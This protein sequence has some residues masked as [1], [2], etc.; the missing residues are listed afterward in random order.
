MGKIQKIKKL[1]KIIVSEWR[2]RYR[3]VFSNEQTHEQRFTIKQITIQ[4]MASTVVIAAF[5]LIALTTVLIAL[6]PLR[7]YIP[8]YTDKKDYKLYKQAVAHIDTLEETI[9]LNQ[10]YI[11]NFRVMV[12]ERVPAADETDADAAA[13]PQ[14]HWKERDKQRSSKTE[15]LIE[16]ADMILDRPKHDKASATPTI[17][18]AK[19]S[20]LSIFPPVYGAVTQLFSVPDNHFG[21]D[22]AGKKNAPVNCIADGVVVFAGYSGG[23]G[24]VIIVQHPGNIVSVYKRNASLLKKAGDRVYAETPIALM[25]NT[26]SAEGEKVHLHFELWYNGFP[27]NPLDYLVIL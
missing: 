21:I 11:D 25:G 2:T 16:E 17:D 9:R 24:F 10:Q 4:K 19:I 5:V 12:E 27:V 6:T 22:I 3:L 14:V 26:G 8:G 1:R 7:L 18:R 15:E 23:E 13:T 20:N